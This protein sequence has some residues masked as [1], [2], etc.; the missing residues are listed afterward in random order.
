MEACP[1][2]GVITYTRNSAEKARL[3]LEAKTGI[4][5]AKPEETKAA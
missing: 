2:E 4:I 1:F 5:E 3:K